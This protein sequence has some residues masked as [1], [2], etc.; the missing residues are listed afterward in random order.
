MSCSSF[1]QQHG[2]LTDGYALEAYSVESMLYIRDKLSNDDAYDHTQEY[3]RGQQTVQ[4]AQL[5]GEG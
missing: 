1:L 2:E 3:E 4:N 5:P